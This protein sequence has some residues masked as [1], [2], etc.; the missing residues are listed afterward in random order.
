VALAGGIDF[1]RALADFGLPAIF[2]EHVLH[3]SNDKSRHGPLQPA[4]GAPDLDCLGGPVETGLSEINN[5]VIIRKRETAT[6]A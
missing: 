3:E 5:C 6:A 1:Q 2:A 4:T